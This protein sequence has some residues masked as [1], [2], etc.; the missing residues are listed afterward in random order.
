MVRPCEQFLVNNGRSLVMRRPK[1]KALIK[2]TRDKYLLAAALLLAC[3]PAIAVLA[4]TDK[5][6]PVRQSVRQLDTRL[7][8]VRCRLGRVLINRPAVSALRC[9]G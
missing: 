2:R 9:R 5:P 7:S 1:T 3:V 6:K 4:L 8:R